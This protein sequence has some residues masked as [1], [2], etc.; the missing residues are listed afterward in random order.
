MITWNDIKDA[1]PGLTK[2]QL[3]SPVNIISMD[4]KV[5]FP[6]VQLNMSQNSFALGAGLPLIS[7]EFDSWEIPDPDDDELTEMDLEIEDND[8]AIAYGN[9]VLWVPS[10]CASERRSAFSRSARQACAKTD[11]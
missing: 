4:G 6:A 1:L 8:Y 7:I 10:L 9:D 5:Y 11:I 2:E 3:E